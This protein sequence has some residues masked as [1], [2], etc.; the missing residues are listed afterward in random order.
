MACYP[1]F[2]SGDGIDIQNGFGVDVQTT[3]IERIGLTASKKPGLCRGKKSECKAEG[4]VD[5]LIFSFRVMLEMQNSGNKNK[6]D[7]TRHC[8]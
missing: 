6:A 1:G 5:V 8:T 3:F 4:Q 7:H 2:D